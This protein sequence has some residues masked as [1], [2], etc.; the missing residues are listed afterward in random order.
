M[1]RSGSRRIGWARLVVYP[2][3]VAM[4]VTTMAVRLGWVHVRA[5]QA[6]HVA[7]DPPVLLRGKTAE[8]QPISV[9]LDRGGVIS[10]LQTSLIAACSNGG[11]DRIGWS[12]DSPRIPFQRTAA[13]VVVKEFNQQ[14]LSAGVLGRRWA[15]SVVHVDRDSISGDAQ[16]YAT[17]RWPSGRQVTCDSGPIHWTAGPSG[18]LPARSAVATYP[19]GAWAGYAWLGHVHSVRAAWTVPAIRAGSPAGVAASWIGAQAPA[20]LPGVPLPGRIPARAAA[21]W[22]AVSERVPF[23]QVGVME[24][25]GWTSS[26]RVSNA[27]FAFWTDS[28]HG[29]QPISLFPVRPGDEISARLTLEDKRWQVMILDATSG[30]HK[31]LYTADEGLASFNEAEWNQENPE[32]PPF[33][34]DEYL[35]PLLSPIHV[36]DLAVNGTPPRRPNMY[37]SWM[38]EDGTYIAPSSLTADG[39]TLHQ[40]GLS[41]SGQRYL[42]IASQMNTAAQAY[43]DDPG[44]AGLPSARERLIKTFNKMALELRRSSWPGNVQ[45]QIDRLIRQTRA[46]TKLVRDQTDP[47]STVS[48]EWM[49]ESAQ[50]ARTGRAI[51]TA[52]NLPQN[53]P[54]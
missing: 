52:L 1:A 20:R 46:L 47:S 51:R 44:R 23:I 3:V 30:A 34:T 49:N 45:A 37:S 38:S 39:F 7:A 53:T 6:R 50:A 13:G 29:F 22:R 35:Y 24:S 9:S 19:L 42:T 41:P 16:Y 21:K 40:T 54:N 33:G 8:G 11:T 26:E 18:S 28:A 43:I 17:Y 4:A 14:E 25:R 48:T 12:P 10:A 32:S 2:L 5:A 27:Y 31:E 15:R 36:R